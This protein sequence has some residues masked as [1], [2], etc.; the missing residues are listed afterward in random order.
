MI[1]IKTE[2][3][4]TS[5]RTGIRKE[6]R[7]TKK[8][9][10][11]E[12]TRE[13]NSADNRK[14]SSLRLIWVRAMQVIHLYLP[15]VIFQFTFSFLP[16][17]CKA[18]TCHIIIYFSFCIHLTARLLEAAADSFLFLKLFYWTILLSIN[19]LNTFF[20]KL[21][22]FCLYFQH[23]PKNFNWCCVFSILFLP[24]FLL[25]FFTFFVFMF[26]F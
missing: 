14:F 19:F 22:T 20:Y 13:A 10:V 2:V 4:H 9:Q 17:T 8:T 18:V 21:C 7:K 23:F 3:S 16:L 6:G 15:L 26:S 5:Y 25:L 24:N 11:Y 1:C 12:Q